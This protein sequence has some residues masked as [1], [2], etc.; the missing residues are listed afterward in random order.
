MVGKMEKI[1][2]FQNTTLGVILSFIIANLPLIQSFITFILT[3]SYLYYKV[4]K[5]KEEYKSI[6]E[7]NEKRRNTKRK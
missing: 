6:K 1:N 2:T 5:T 4:R 7:K 3:A